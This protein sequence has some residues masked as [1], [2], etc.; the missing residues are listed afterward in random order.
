MLRSSLSF[1]TKSTLKETR[2]WFW[3][4]WR[5]GHSPAG[6]SDLKP[7]EDDQLVPLAALLTGVLGG[8]LLGNLRRKAKPKPLTVTEVEMNLLEI[9][10]QQASHSCSSCQFGPSCSA[11]GLAWPELGM[12][13]WTQ[14]HV[15]FNRHVLSQHSECNV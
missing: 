7:L 15:R 6:V 3:Q 1:S 8:T 9:S 10:T 2:A 4:R 13:C 11:S 14:N 12:D 5:S